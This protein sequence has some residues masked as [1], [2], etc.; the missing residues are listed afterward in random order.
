MAPHVPLYPHPCPSQLSTRVAELGAEVPRRGIF[1]MEAEVKA[2]KTKSIV[3]E[4]EA[5]TVKRKSMEAEAIKT[6]T[7]SIASFGFEFSI[8]WRL[9]I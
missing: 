9:F 6:C 4:A 3:A 7:A 2:V 1:L 5:E 8:F